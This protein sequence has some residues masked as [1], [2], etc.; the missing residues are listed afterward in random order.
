M[1]GRR[2]DSGGTVA[3]APLPETAEAR[4][5]TLAMYQELVEMDAERGL[6]GRIAFFELDRSPLK[7]YGGSIMYDRCMALR[8]GGPKVFMLLTCQAKWPWH[9]PGKA[10]PCAGPRWQPGSAPPNKGSSH[11]RHRECFSSA[12]SGHDAAAHAERSLPD[13]CLAPRRAEHPFPERTAEHELQP[14][15]TAPPEP[16]ARAGQ[17]TELEAAELDEFQALFE[18]YESSLAGSSKSRQGPEAIKALPWP[19]SWSTGSPSSD[20]S[21][22]S[23][24]R[25]PGGKAQQ[26]AST[27]ASELSHDSTAA[28]AGASAARL[29][30]DV[31][32]AAAQAT[33]TG[34]CASACCAKPPWATSPPLRKPAREFTRGS[35]R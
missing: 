15:V 28:S 2:R 18:D 30:A 1:A 9:Q 19:R 23:C 17:G 35:S 5:L 24:S 26:A 22:P 25:R 8:T 14:A 27:A 3:G 16:P 29:P 32:S 34:P 4:R 6:A 11:A 21:P 20:R 33:A 10:L 31:R 12:A 13:R 7:S